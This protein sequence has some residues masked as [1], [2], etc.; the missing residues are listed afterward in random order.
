MRLAW[1]TLVNHLCA[2]SNDI[3]VT[4]LVGYS[5]RTSKKFQKENLMGV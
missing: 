1:V 4:A 3:P 5:S 2:L